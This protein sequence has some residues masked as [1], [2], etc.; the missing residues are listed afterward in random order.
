MSDPNFTNKV[1]L[2]TGAGSGIGL[3][4]VK[5]FKALGSS[6]IAI[7]KDLNALSKSS[8]INKEDLLIELDLT[9]IISLKKAFLSVEKRYLKLKFRF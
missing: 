9:N 6:I 8:F 1:T 4:A 7:D 5:S 3:E 2:I